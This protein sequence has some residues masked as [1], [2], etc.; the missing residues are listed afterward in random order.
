MI[1][2]RTAETPGRKELLMHFLRAFAVSVLSLAL[3]EYKFTAKN[4][5]SAKG[6]QNLN[7]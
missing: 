3:L 6:Y 2:Y 4:A 1:L 7:K 5:K